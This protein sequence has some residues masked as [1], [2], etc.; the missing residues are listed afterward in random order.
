MPKLRIGLD[1]QHLGRPKRPGDYGAAV[2]TDGDGHADTLE[3]LLTP[4]IAIGALEYLQSHGHNVYL[5]GDGE[6]SERHARADRYKLNVYLALH[7]NAGKGDYGAFFYHP[8]SPPRNG[9][10]LATALGGAWRRAA[11]EITGGPFEVKAIRTSAS[12]WT[13]N[14]LYTIRDLGRRTTPIGICCEPWFLDNDDH[15]AAFSTGAGLHRTGR[16]LGEGVQAW[17]AGHYAQQGK[18]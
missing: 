10:D 1:I 12:D 5:F 17:I 7:L 15:R 16:A 13:R 14:A 6:Y 4:R 18:T 9:A 8:E 11:E 3:A 2:D